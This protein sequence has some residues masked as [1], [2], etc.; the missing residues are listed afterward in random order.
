MHEIESRDSPL[1]FPAA[2]HHSLSPVRFFLFANRGMLSFAGSGPNS[3]TTQVRGM[4]H[5]SVWWKGWVKGA[6]CARAQTPHD[7]LNQDVAYDV[8]LGLWPASRLRPTPHTLVP[9]PGPHDAERLLDRMS[10]RTYDPREHTAVERCVIL[11]LL[12][13][14]LRVSLPARLVVASF[15]RRSSRSQICPTWARPHGKPLSAL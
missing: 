3:R 1:C 6:A 5:P 4:L 7:V 15:F 9:Q 10:S 12:L 8:L 14:C 11:L 2:T 13:L